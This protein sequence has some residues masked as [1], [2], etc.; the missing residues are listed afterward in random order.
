[1]S[2]VFVA[3]SDAKR[4]GVL[5]SLAV[6]AKTAAEI[7]KSTGESVAVV[8]KHLA[9]LV[10]SGLVKAS[11]AKTP[12]Y[13]SNPAALKPLGLWVAK[14]AGAELN[15]EFQARAGELADKAGVLANQGSAWLAKKINPKSKAKDVEGL[16]KELGRFF[17]DAKKTANDELG[18]TV[19]KA[20]KEVK[21]K[22]AEVTKKPA[23]KKPAPKKTAA[24]PAAK[25]APAKKAAV[26][27]TAKP[28]A[29]KTAAKKP[30]AKKA[31]K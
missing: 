24:K 31:T 12:V 15:A 4:R 3:I 27:T 11:K 8:E 5:E 10:A 28:A 30:A 19:S 16:A 22:V 13:S 23:A 9:I 25:K 26:K 6:S 7:A 14:F 18:E 29:K 17:A 21:S 1:M 20:V 2:D